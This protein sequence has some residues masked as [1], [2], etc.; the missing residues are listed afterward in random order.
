MIGILG[1]IFVI[2]API[3]VYRNARQNGHNAVLWTLLAICI[4]VGFQVI[5]PLLIGFALGVIWVNQGYTAAEIQA[6][7]ETPSIILGVT[8]LILSI[9]GIL[10]IMRHVNTIRDIKEDY[11]TPPAPPNFNQ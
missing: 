11:P 8:S 3:F 2:V 4:G 7:L 9:G 5:I 1:L 6:S 10:L